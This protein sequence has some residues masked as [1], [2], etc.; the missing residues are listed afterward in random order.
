MEPEVQGVW[1]NEEFMQW[2][3]Q[4]IPSA[5]YIPLSFLCHFLALHIESN[6]KSWAMVAVGF[7]VSQSKIGSF[8]TWVVFW[9]KGDIS[10]QR[11]RNF[12][13]SLDYLEEF[14]LGVLRIM[15]DCQTEL[16]HML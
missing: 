16:I 3:T 4:N 6:I 12:C 8:G 14:E 11:R 10:C 7:R 5:K 2:T 13:P 1:N 15:G 9:A